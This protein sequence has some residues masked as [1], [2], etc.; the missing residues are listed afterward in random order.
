MNDVKTVFPMCYL[1]IQSGNHFE[2][3]SEAR[4]TAKTHFPVITHIS[5]TFP[6][7]VSS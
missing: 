4:E 7:V 1:L 3:K 2:Y 5:E 6:D